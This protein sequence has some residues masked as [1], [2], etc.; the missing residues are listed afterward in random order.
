MSY[1]QVLLTLIATVKVIL[2][3]AFQTTVEMTANC[4]ISL[5]FQQSCMLVLNQTISWSIVVLDIK[6]ILHLLCHYTYVIGLL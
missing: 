6:K 5:N 3:H 2:W 4:H 1:I